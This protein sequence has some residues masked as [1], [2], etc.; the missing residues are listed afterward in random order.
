MAEERARHVREVLENADKWER[1][2]DVDAQHCQRLL[3]AILH[4]NHASPCR[5]LGDERDVFKCIVD[6]AACNDHFDKTARNLRFHLLSEVGA[7][8]YTKAIYPQRYSD[9]WTGDDDKRV[10]TA[11]RRH[12]RDIDRVVNANMRWGPFVLERLGGIATLTVAK[13]VLFFKSKGD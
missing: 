9:D 5:A 2:R 8:T 6:T 10:A 4:F 3:E 11:V 1:L 7:P 13:L 12:Q